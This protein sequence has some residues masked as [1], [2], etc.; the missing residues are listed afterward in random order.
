[1]TPAWAQGS[2]VIEGQVFNGSTDGAPLPGLTVTL[3]TFTGSEAEGSQETTTD[4]E[5]RFRFEDL[6]TEQYS[7]RFEVHYAGIDYGSQVLAFA[8]GQGLISVPFTVFD[9]TTSDE[10][11]SVQR[12]HLIFSFQPG[13][14]TVQEVQ[15]L[16]NAGNTTYVGT[17]GQEDGPT[18]Q[19]AMPEGAAAVQLLEGLMECCVVETETGLAS[20]LP[21]F[22]GTKQFVFSYELHPQATTYD[23]TRRIVYPTESLDVLVSNV[24]VELTSHGLTGGEVISLQGR[25]YIHLSGASLAAGATITLHFDNIPLEG[26]TTQVPQDG[27][28]LLRWLIIGAMAVAAGAALAYPLLR[29]SEETS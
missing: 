28:P 16:F 11:L 20:T 7:Y 17:S 19:F 15:V 10:A 18:V 6:E 5:G 12:A 9:A 29:R 26:A 22:P 21:L 4:D 2:G 23:L 13:T 24:G 27:N 14:I 25:D 1:V 3:F 8:E